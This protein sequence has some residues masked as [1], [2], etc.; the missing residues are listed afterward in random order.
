MEGNS[1]GGP[2]GG[3]AVSLGNGLGGGGGG[4]GQN[5][6]QLLQ[7][8]PHWA[9]QQQQHFFNTDFGQGQQQQG[10]PGGQQSLHHQQMLQQQQLMQLAAAQ[11]AGSGPGQQ[12]PQQGQ[13]H[14]NQMVIQFTCFDK[15]KSRFSSTFLNNKLFGYIALWYYH[16][17]V[18]QN[19]LINLK[20]V[21][22]EYFFQDIFVSHG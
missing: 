8:P 13:Q 1:G 4:G 7:Q 21:L 18:V 20:K 22:I 16:I 11:V 6:Q 12:G 2:L 14:M 9:S 10:G 15:H 17:V 3:V 19:K 5:M